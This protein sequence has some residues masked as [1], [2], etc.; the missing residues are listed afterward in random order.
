LEIPA[1]RALVAAGQQHD[2]GRPALHVI[3]PIA[4]AI[5]DPKLRHGF[6]HRRDVVRIT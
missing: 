3:D 5:I 4:R 6:S 2:R 1:L